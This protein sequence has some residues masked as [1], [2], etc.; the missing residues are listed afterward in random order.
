MNC[1]Q[2]ALVTVVNCE[3]TCGLIEASAY[4]SHSFCY[5]D[6]GF[7][8]LPP[9]DYAAI[10]VTIGW[11]IFTEEAIREAIATAQGCLPENI[12]RL[13]VEIALLAAVDPILTAELDAV[14]AYFQ[15]LP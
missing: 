6:S 3:A 13:E 11:G 8:S 5:I 14:L 9:L 2:R 12:Q 1:L 4:A 7:C 15:S 10:L